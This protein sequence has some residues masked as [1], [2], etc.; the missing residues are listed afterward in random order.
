MG[1]VGNESRGDE[2]CV[3][4]KSGVSAKIA[5]IVDKEELTV[6][7]HKLSGKNPKYSPVG[8]R[9]YVPYQH[10]TFTIGN[11]KE[12]CQRHFQTIDSALFSSPCDILASDWEPS[13]NNIEQMPN[14]N[15]IYL[16]FLEVPLIDS[17]ILL[18]NPFGKSLNHCEGSSVFHCLQCCDW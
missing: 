2:R 5:E 3:N 16:R 14:I 18:K 17:N 11:I 12:A 1:K 7:R 8:A 10:C 4:P 13:C 15:L 6:Q 9:E